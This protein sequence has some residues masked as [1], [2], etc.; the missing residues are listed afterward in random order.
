MEIRAS[1]S[2]SP[3][4][5]TVSF[6]LVPQY[7]TSQNSTESFNYE[8]VQGYASFCELF[9]MNSNCNLEIIWLVEPSAPPANVQGHNTSSTS[10]WVDW[11][12]VSFT[13]Q[14]GIILT[15]AVTYKALPDETPQSKVMIAPTTQANLTGLTKYRNYSI[16][17]FS[18]TAKGDGNVSEPIIVITDED[19]KL[20]IVQVYFQG[21]F[22][23]MKKKKFIGLLIEW[24]K[25][26][27]SHRFY[28]I[29]MVG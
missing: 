10:I 4:T 12:I 18:S 13:D 16:T 1:Q 17:V 3:Q 19:S 27:D 9:Y 21:S 15:C 2:L 8:N 22:N 6:L 5:K 28:I 25:K 7:L 14:N 20:S 26:V 29:I 11:D 23:L 24:E